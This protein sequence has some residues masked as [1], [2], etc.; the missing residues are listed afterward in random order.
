MHPTSTLRTLNLVVWGSSNFSYRK[1]KEDDIAIVAAITVTSE[2][3]HRG[4]LLLVQVSKLVSGV[5]HCDPR[6]LR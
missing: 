4:T 3:C 1:N 2:P 5:Y 6:G